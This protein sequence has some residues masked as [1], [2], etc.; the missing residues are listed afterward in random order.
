MPAGIIGMA[1]KISPIPPV[2]GVFSGFTFEKMKSP[3]APAIHRESIGKKPTGMRPFQF[4]TCIPVLVLLL[5]L[6]QSATTISHTRNRKYTTINPADKYI[7]VTFVSAT[8][9]AGSG[10][11]LDTL[12]TIVGNNAMI[13]APEKRIPPSI[14]LPARV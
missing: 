11:L 6:Y 1:A 14:N 8:P 4:R 5:V 7:S 3:I 10:S 12:V 13:M 9:F 2:N